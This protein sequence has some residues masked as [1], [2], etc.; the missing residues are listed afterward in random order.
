M[1]AELRELRPWCCAGLSGSELRDR[2]ARGIARAKAHELRSELGLCLY[3]HLV[4]TFGDD[5]DVELPW[6]AAILDDRTLD[7]QERI[8]GLYELAF[9]LQTAESDGKREP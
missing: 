5:F 4:F 9:A 1:A 8:E 6:A 3:V 2:V 7:A